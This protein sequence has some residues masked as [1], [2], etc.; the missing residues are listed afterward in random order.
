MAT[1]PSRPAIAVTGL[2]KSFGDQV[3]LDGIDLEVSEGTI[4]ALLM[5]DLRHRARPASA[6]ASAAAWSPAREQRALAEALSR[7][8]EVSTC[9]SAKARR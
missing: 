5:A 6:W 3:V 2:R 8:A 7:T 1:I 4:F 9:S